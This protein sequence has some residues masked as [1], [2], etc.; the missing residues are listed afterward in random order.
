VQNQLASKLHE[1]EKKKLEQTKN[2]MSNQLGNMN[3]L[4]KKKE[5]EL[6]TERKVFE[7]KTNDVMK[8]R[9]EAKDQVG[10]LRTKL[11]ELIKNKMIFETEMK[12]K[13]QIMENEH[14]EKMKEKEKQLKLAKEQL[15]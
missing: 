8:E 12:N 11:S 5:V 1:E 6:H 10:Q 4:L 3:D 7:N 13:Q 9:D 14:L 2:I 15:K